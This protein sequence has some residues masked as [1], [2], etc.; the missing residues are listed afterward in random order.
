VSASDEVW[1]DVRTA[2]LG[3]ADLIEGLDERQAATPSLCEGWRV[4]DV[5][6]H[7]VQ[8]AEASQVSMARDVARHGLLPQRALQRVAVEVGSQPLDELAGRLR[9]AADGRFRVLGLPPA[10]VLGEVVV[11]REDVLRPLGTAVDVAP[12]SLVPVLDLYARIGR[13]AFGR[14][15]RGVTLST[16]DTGW[17]SGKGPVVEGRAL[18]VLLLLAGRRSAARDLAGPGL[19]E[20]GIGPDPGPVVDPRT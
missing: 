16:T 15:F 8:L 19:A 10:T 4:R 9:A 17:R 14:S 1:H 12:D 13:V 6:G 11:H 2:R 18:E 20:A 3:L 5:V 7:L